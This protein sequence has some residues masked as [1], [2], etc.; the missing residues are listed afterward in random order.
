MAVWKAGRRLPTDA[1]TDMIR[2]VGTRA[3]YTI[4]I[5]CRIEAEHDSCTRSLSSFISGT[6]R[7]IQL[8]VAR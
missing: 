2:L 7:S 8:W 3:T 4:S 6:A 5:P 1:A